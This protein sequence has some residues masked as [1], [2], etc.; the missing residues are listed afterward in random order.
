[1]RELHKSQCHGSFCFS[2]TGSIAAILT[3]SVQ[4][5][6][7]SL[8]A[9]TCKY[10]YLDRLNIFSWRLGGYFWELVHLHIAKC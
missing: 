6:Y 1:M 8:H 9:V 3:L 7:H 5:R 10:I 2:F 4:N